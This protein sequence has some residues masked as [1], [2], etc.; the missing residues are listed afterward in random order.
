MFPPTSYTFV[1]C[2]QLLAKVFL[3]FGFLVFI[4]I[5]G[6]GK[7]QST[8]FVEWQIA[9]VQYTLFVVSLFTLVHSL[10]HLLIHF[11]LHRN[12]II[13]LSLG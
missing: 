10:T 1:Q 13:I 9:L 8:E 7:Q 4:T 3:H 2:I 5:L 12:S 6:K 11:T